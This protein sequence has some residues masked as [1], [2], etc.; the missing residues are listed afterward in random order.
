MDRKTHIVYVECGI[1]FFSDSWWQHNMAYSEPFQIEERIRE[2]FIDL[3]IGFFVGAK[4][5]FTQS[6]RVGWGPE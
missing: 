3:I 6:D 2:R 1:V 4:R 5:T